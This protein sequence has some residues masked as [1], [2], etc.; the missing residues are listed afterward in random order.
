M[1]VWWEGGKVVRSSISQFLDDR[2]IAMDCGEKK[3]G[4]GRERLDRKGTSVGSG[5][6]D[7]VVLF[8]LFAMSALFV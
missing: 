5:L 2:N 3:G 1:V 7:R 6:F 4:G 8:V